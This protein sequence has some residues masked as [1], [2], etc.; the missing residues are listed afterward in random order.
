MVNLRATHNSK[1]LLYEDVTESL[2]EHGNI[3][4]DMATSRAIQVNTDFS[5]WDGDGMGA[6]LREQIATSF[7]GIKCELRMYL[8]SNEV[9]DKK[10][11]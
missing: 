11:K 2:A 7:K 3:A 6:L 4:N 8:C 10:S 5:V 9:E 1:V